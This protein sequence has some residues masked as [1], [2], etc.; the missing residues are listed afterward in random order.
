MLLSIKEAIMSR[1]FFSPSHLEYNFLQSFGAIHIRWLHFGWVSLATYLSPA[2]YPCSSDTL[3]HPVGRLRSPSP[4]TDTMNSPIKM[5]ILS[6]NSNIRFS[7]T[8]F[9]GTPRLPTQLWNL[10]PII[11]LKQHIKKNINTTIN[12]SCSCKEFRSRFLL[13][14]SG[15]LPCNLSIGINHIYIHPCIFLRIL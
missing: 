1:S 9:E 8:L 14:F 4:Q 5:I 11:I 6:M 12:S 7:S 15:K 10:F 3:F 2:N 13:E